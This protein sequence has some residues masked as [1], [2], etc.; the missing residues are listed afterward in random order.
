MVQLRLRS[1]GRA[2]DEVQALQGLAS[3]FDF[4]LL[5]H[6][7]GRI[8]VQSQL[9]CRGGERE[10]EREPQPRVQASPDR[11]SASS[12]SAGATK[13]GRTAPEYF[14]KGSEEQGRGEMPPSCEEPEPRSSRERRRT[15]SDRKPQRPQS[16]PTAGE[17]PQPC[18]RRAGEEAPRGL[19]RRGSRGESKPRTTRDAPEG[20]RSRAASPPSRPASELEE[21]AAPTGQGQPRA[22][23]REAEA[24]A[25]CRRGRG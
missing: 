13:S 18:R 15:P 1:P 7:R 23:P 20:E 24:E 11:S 25:R 22:P 2:V 14:W 6:V 16:S 3:S 21:A 4:L 8:V 17:E 9:R 10:P 19:P 5:L 12:G